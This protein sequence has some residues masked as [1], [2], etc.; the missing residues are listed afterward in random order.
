[1]QVTHHPISGR[2]PAGAEPGAGAL[3]GSH[4]TAQAGTGAAQADAARTDAAG[5]GTADA[6]VAGA[7]GEVLRR[8]LRPRVEEAASAD[9]VFGRD[10]AEPVARFA[11][12]GGKRM[13]SQLLWWGMRA[14]GGDAQAADAALHVAAGVE[15]LQTCALL[16][17]DVMDGAQVRRGRPA[18]HVAWHDARPGV[19]RA[20]PGPTFGDS[21]AIL[22]GDLALAWADDTVATAP[23]RPDRAAAVRGLWQVLRTE[24]AAGQYV[25]L[26]SQAT[27]CRSERTAVRTA[28]LKSALYSVQ[29]PLELGAALAGAGRAA[30]DALSVAGRCAGLAFQLRDDLTDAFG[31]PARTGVPTDSDIRAGKPTYLVAVARR[32]A[33]RSGDRAALRVLD[34]RAGGAGLSPQA[35]AEVRQVLESIGARA[36]VEA[37]IAALTARALDHLG[38]PLAGLGPVA[39]SRIGDLFTAATRAAGNAASRGPVADQAELDPVI[40]EVLSAAGHVTEKED[41][42]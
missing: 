29:R 38:A 23:L 30:A 32:L 21:A 3:P 27:G 1:M 26:H 35:Q 9:P 2:R 16:H 20:V 34:R 40:A 41:M 10:V 5:T 28:L 42:R 19:R 18:F 4:G 12:H 39:R 11:L 13:R 22:A 8:L 6:D 36:A 31:D 24:M 37:Q 33:Q 25:D 17:D 15:L 14:C 7:V